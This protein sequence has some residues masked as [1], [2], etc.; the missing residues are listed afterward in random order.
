M[1]LVRNPQRRHT[2]GF[3]GVKF[4]E[5]PLREDLDDRLER[6]EELLIKHQV[7]DILSIPLYDRDLHTSFIFDRMADD[8]I[9]EKKRILNIDPTDKRFNFDNE[10]QRFVNEQENKYN[11]NEQREDKRDRENSRDSAF[12]SYHGKFSL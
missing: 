2:D 1:K 9:V 4:R 6:R 8:E 5:R 12:S 10:I 7:P 11:Q 3:I